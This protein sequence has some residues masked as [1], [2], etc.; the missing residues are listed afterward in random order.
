MMEEIRDAID[1]G[2]YKEYKEKTLAGFE[3][4]EK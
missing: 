4:K 3:T 2:Y 1:G